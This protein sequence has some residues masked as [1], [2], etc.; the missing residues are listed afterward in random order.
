MHILKSALFAFAVL[1]AGG[2]HAHDFKAGTLTIIHPHARAT[3]SAAPVA[4]GYMTIVNSG[5]EADRLLGGS[6]EFAA[7]VEVHEMTM[8]GDVMKMRHLADGL[9]IPAGGTVILKPG[10]VHIMFVKITE[11]FEKDQIRPVLLRFEK[12]GEV[13]VDFVVEAMGASGNHGQ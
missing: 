3:P 8:A 12:A 10:A 5:G 1:I 4:G 13:E 11:R 9:E 7:R 6:A 2:A